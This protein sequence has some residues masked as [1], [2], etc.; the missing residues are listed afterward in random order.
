M[1]G[2][3]R[4]VWV[5]YHS[6]ALKKAYYRTSCSYKKSTWRHNVPANRSGTWRKEGRKN[7]LLL[8]EDNE[9]GKHKR[10]RKGAEN[11]GIQYAENA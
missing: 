9:K 3:Q 10:T 8:E 4:K 11:A 7:G 1:E 2:E 6:S 5:E